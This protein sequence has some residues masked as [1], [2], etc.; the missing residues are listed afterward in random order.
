MNTLLDKPDISDI[1]EPTEE[2]FVLDSEEK[3]NWLLCKLANLEAE[4]NRVKAQSEKMLTMLDSEINGLRFRFEDD[5]RAFTAERLA[6]SGGRRKSVHL[7]Q[8]TLSFRTVPA[9]L[10]IADPQAALDYAKVLGLPV[11]TLTTIDTQ[12][13]R[14]KAHK[15]L[16]ETGEL[17]PGVELTPEAERFS[18]RFGKE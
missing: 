11:H 16:M 18:I 2:R 7:L 3:V 13:Y 10:K 14:E 17:L 6:Q 12:V 8:G 4:R 5:L 1:L 15:A 9:S